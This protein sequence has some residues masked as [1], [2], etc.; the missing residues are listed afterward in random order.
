MKKLVLLFA[1]IIAFASC[2]KEE[3]DTTAPKI[4]SVRVNGVSADEHDLN[5]GT[6]I[7]IAVDVSDNEAL[8]QVK[9]DIHAADDGHTHDDSSTGEMEAPNIGAW[10]ELRTE[11]LSGKS[12]TRTFNLTVPATIAGHWHIEVKLI[13]KEGNEATEYITTLHIENENLPVFNVTS[14]PATVNYE[15]EVPINGTIT[16]N[17]N[18]TDPDGLVEVHWELENETTGAVVMEGEL[19]GVTGTSF[20]LGSIAIGPIAAGEYHLH[21]HAED[22]QGYVGEWAVHVHAE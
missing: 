5:A 4:N 10:S 13:D 1:V 17:G 8:N 18:V 16:L 3:T 22:S 19:P 15:I 20:D 21:I 2:K 14:T 6:A 9:L 12:T 7:E 11:N